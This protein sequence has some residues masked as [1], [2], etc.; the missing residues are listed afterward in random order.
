MRRVH[1]VHIRVA[2]TGSVHSACN[3]T[4]KNSNEA[5]LKLLSHSHGSAVAD[6]LLCDWFLFPEIILASTT[7]AK[8]ALAYLHTLKLASELTKRF[9]ETSWKKIKFMVNIVC[10]TRLK[11]Q[12]E[13]LN[14]LKSFFKANYNRKN[15]HFPF[16]FARFLYCPS[17]IHL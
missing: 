16:E 2:T 9:R 17:L 12:S 15:R 5:S 6:V 10:Q 4:V 3:I 8:L 11:S 14:Y 13:C 1:P 7:T